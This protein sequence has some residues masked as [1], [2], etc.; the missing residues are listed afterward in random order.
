MV[1]HPTPRWQ[2][3]IG[4]KRK[5]A[6]VEKRSIFIT[7]FFARKFSLLIKFL[8]I[9]VAQKFSQ[10]L[11]LFTNETPT[12]IVN[13]KIKIKKMNLLMKDDSIPETRTHSTSMCCWHWTKSSLSQHSALIQVPRQCEGR[14]S[15]D[16]QSPFRS[17]TVSYTIL[18]R[19]RN[20]NGS[21]RR[22]DRRKSSN[23]VTLMK[24]QDILAEIEREEKLQT[25]KRGDASVCVCACVFKTAGHSW[26][27]TGRV[28]KLT[29]PGT[30][31]RE[32][33]ALK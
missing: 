15:A 5:L 20:R 30:V 3:E 22:N 17:W 14:P 32:R 10:F 7:Y 4:L 23:A 29:S 21:P 33:C 1:V 12:E 31:F 27:I 26:W 2:I 16:A 19:T 25:G 11:K 24:A 8:A 28:L 9:Q 18:T 13:K 6:L